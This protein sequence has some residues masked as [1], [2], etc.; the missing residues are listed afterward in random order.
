MK[1]LSILF[2]ILVML[3][4]ASTAFARLDFM[5]PVLC[6]AG[7]WLVVNAANESVVQVILP[8]GTPY[9]DAGHCT[10]PAPVAPVITNVVTQKGL[11]FLMTVLLTD[12]S[13]ASTP[14]VTAAYGSVSKTHLNFGK[15]PMLFLFLLH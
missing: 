3:V 14:T 8:E 1:K 6:V 7:H 4:T 15:G 12:S 13:Q 11:G 10:G 5:D 9:G 2:V